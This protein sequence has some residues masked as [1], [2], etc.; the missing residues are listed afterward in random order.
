MQRAFLPAI[1]LTALFLGGATSASAA[2]KPNPLFSDGAVLQRGMPVPVWGTASEGER[3]T[4]TFQGQRVST[5]AKDG[6]WMVRLRS[7]RAGGP[8]EMTI[9]GENTI[10]VKNVLVGEVWI[11]SGQS[12]MQ[13]TLRQSAGA[14]E[15]IANSRN[16]QI[17]L[18]TIERKA[19]DEPLTEV[20]VKWEEAAPETVPNFSGV[21]YFFGRDLQKDLGVPVGLIST[22]VGGTPAEAWTSR[23]VLE[24]HPQLKQILANHA[25]AQADWPQTQARF[26][27][28][29]KRYQQ[30]A[31]KARQAGQ[32]VPAAP[33][34]PQDPA[35]SAQR[36]TGLY[37]AMIAPLVP[38]AIRGAIWYQGESNASRA[39]EY[40]TLFPAMIKNWRQAWGQGDFPFLLVQL[41]PF[42]KITQEPGE[43]AWAELREAQRQTVHTLPNTGMAV[44]TDVGE[45]DDIHPK[46]KE[47]VGHRLE[48]A[49]LAVAYGRNVPYSGPEF[50]R[51]WLEGNRAVLSFQH[52]DELVAKGGTLTGFT[53]AGSDRKWV[54]AQAEIRQDKDGDH[55]V[56]WSPEVAQPVAVR[57]GWANYPLGNL[58]NGAGLPASPFRSDDWPLSTMPAATAAAATRR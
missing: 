28:Q 37:N 11:A 21:A 51:M 43:S 13:W 39:Y 5:V 8:F 7:L 38:Y 32:P 35:K 41:A 47:P 18:V 16:P 56:V 14:D 27:E 49:A 3:V 10:P 31:E 19:T 52:A 12:N 23:G 17:R 48:L 44:I 36:P 34:P 54:N 20:P 26:Q 4:V 30:E 53:V 46:K 33:R 45:E 22:N 55:V 58:W 24:N 25:K 1:L 9:E 57:Y 50:R 29:L 40:G 6:K 42:M 15:A 2:V